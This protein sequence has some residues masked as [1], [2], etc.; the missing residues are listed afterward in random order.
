[1]PAWEL[2]F[3]LSLLKCILEDDDGE[4]NENLVEK[5]LGMVEEEEEGA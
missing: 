2:L 5:I 1:M 4:R 3:C